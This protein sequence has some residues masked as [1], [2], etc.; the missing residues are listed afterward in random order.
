M[1]NARKIPG[2]S[3]LK[4]ARWEKFGNQHLTHPWLAFYVVC[5][6]STYV[7]H[8]YHGLSLSGGALPSKGIVMFIRWLVQ[9]SLRELDGLEMA[10]ISSRCNAEHF[11]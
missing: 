4:S 10:F 5:T 9:S 1:S 3:F 7:K 2:F 8:H 11:Q 6:Y